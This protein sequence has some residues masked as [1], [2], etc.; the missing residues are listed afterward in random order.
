MRLLD[1]EFNAVDAGFD[2]W[3]GEA[4][5]NSALSA[6]TIWS[7]RW[8]ELQDCVADVR[9]RGL[10]QSCVRWSRIGFN[11][12]VRGRLIGGAMIFRTKPRK[13]ASTRFSEFIRNASSAERKK[14]YMVVLARAT[15][16]QRR[17][18][19]KAAAAR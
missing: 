17:V 5:S 3:S 6:A 10:A 12:S 14:V 16:R 7:W 15:E 8:G 19:S 2:L 13:V 9:L 1:R 11:L 18:L 4:S